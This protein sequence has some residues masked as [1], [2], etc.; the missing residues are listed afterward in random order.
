MLAEWVYVYVHYY[1][2]IYS[3]LQILLSSVDYNTSKCLSTIK[4]TPSAQI[5]INIDSNSYLC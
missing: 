4:K 2:Y 5:N 1:V 3:M